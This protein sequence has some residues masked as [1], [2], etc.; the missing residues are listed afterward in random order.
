MAGA[1]VFLISFPTVSALV[2][3][4]PVSVREITSPVTLPYISMSLRAAKSRI[5]SDDAFRRQFEPNIDKI[6]GFLAVGDPGGELVL[7][8]HT[9]TNQ[10]VEC[11]EKIPPLTSVCVLVT[12]SVDAQ[13]RAFLSAI[14]RT[15]TRTIIVI[16]SLK[17]AKAAIAAV[18]AGLAHAIL[19]SEEH[20]FDAQLRVTIERLNREYLQ[21][22]SARVRTYLAKGPTEF[23]ED[24]IISRMIDNAVK[25]YG[26]EEVYV[27]LDPPGLMLRKQGAPSQ[28]LFICDEDYY[29]G[30]Q[31]ISQDLIEE[32]AP[33]HPHQAVP[34]FSETPQDDFHSRLL[35]SIEKPGRNRI[36][37][38]KMFRNA[39]ADRSLFER[40]LGRSAAR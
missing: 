5:L 24:P 14:R 1:Q 8:V 31:E 11:G 30:M 18:N 7:R 27:R 20:D 23:L 12:K 39:G 38:Y 35:E 16:K 2:S 9:P 33:E 19:L 17:H 26:A 4:I 28:F 10:R 37:Y 29:T 21:S 32:Q 40:L 25:K 22:V 36:W 34:G 13:K 6:E 15:H 3:D